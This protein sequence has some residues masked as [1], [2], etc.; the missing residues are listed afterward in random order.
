M[1]TVFKMSI[2]MIS[3]MILLSACSGSEEPEVKPTFTVGVSPV[4]ELTSE[5]ITPTLT[6]PENTTLYDESW[7]S[8]S[9]PSDAM[10][11]IENSDST[12]QGSSVYVWSINGYDVTL[13]KGKAELN[14]LDGY[15]GE[16]LA[17]D[18]AMYYL[19]MLDGSSTDEKTVEAGPLNGWGMQGYYVT[20][21][22]VN[23]DR[24]ATYFF[25]NAVDFIKFTYAV[26]YDQPLPHDIM[27]TLVLKEDQQ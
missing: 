24:Y 10:L 4:R 26:P 16:S 19:T 7:F 2:P 5:T 13:E 6:A 21:S 22:T 20:Q 11:N 1:K 9:L 25:S 14:K 17:E 23:E 18:Q 3:I 15:A 27:N 12:G 8:L